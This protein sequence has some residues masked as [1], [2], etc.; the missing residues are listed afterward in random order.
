MVLV[1]RLGLCQGSAQVD[2]A[3]PAHGVQD[4]AGLRRTG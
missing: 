1:T 2:A 3:G 4:Q